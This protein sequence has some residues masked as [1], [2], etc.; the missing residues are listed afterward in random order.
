MHF[1]LLPFHVGLFRD[2]MGLFAPEP[3]IVSAIPGGCQRLLLHFVRPTQASL[4]R[5]FSSS[6]VCNARH[7]LN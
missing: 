3:G 6:R 5:H 1:L 4:I 7:W 2:L